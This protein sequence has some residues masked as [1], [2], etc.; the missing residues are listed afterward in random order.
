MYTPSPVTST[1][2]VVCNFAKLHLQYS[3]VISGSLVA[4]YFGVS[5]LLETVLIEPIQQIQQ[6]DT[7][8]SGMKDKLDGTF[9]EAKGKVKETAG[10]LTDNPRLEAEGT[11]EKLA[12]KVQKKIGQVKQVLRNY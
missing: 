8:K 10:N 6:E 11:S 9:H 7:M 1:M 2:I 5:W 3:Q 4:I 12:G